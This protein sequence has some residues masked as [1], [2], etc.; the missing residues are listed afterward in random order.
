MNQCMSPPSEAKEPVRA[1]TPCRAHVTDV[2]MP[3]PPFYGRGRDRLSLAHRAVYGCGLP[4]PE[5]FT[6]PRLG[7]TTSSSSSAPEEP[8]HMNALGDGQ[9]PAHGEMI[10][11]EDVWARILVAR[12]P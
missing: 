1:S 2:A 3:G 6:D 12:S 5:L 10:W 11:I 8:V 9:H 7:A 4:P